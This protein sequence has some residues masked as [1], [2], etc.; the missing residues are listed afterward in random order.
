MYATIMEGTANDNVAMSLGEELF[1]AV[2][3]DKSADQEV[4]WLQKVFD[5]HQR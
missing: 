5:N 2:G 3:L 1:L 4:T